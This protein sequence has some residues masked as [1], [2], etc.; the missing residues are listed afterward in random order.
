MNQQ[1]LAH[2]QKK[3]LK[4]VPEIRAGY[5]IK[6]HQKIKEGEKERVQ[7]FEGLVIKVKGS[8]ITQIATVRKVVSGVGVEKTFPLH[9][10]NITKIEVKKIGKVRR[11]K[12]YYMRERAGKSAR[13]REQHVDISV[14][15]EP[16]HKDEPVKETVEENT[17][18]EAPVKEEAK[19]EE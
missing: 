2:V 18:S 13:L 5:T 16:R 10:D 4:N 15:L 11:A 12:L 8:G 7:T 3:H 19:T 6:V 17:E 14:D 9:S 1:I